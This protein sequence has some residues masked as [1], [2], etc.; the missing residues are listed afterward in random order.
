MCAT[1]SRD[2]VHSPTEQ[3]SRAAAYAASTPAWPAPMTMT[4]NFMKRP[5]MPRPIFRCRSARRCARAR[6]AGAGADD[7]VKLQAC[8]LKVAQDEL[9]GVCASRAC[10]AAL[11]VRQGQLHQQDVPDVGDRHAHRD[12]VGLRQ[13]AERI[14]AP[15]F[16]DALRR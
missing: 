12:S 6:L 9:F 10:A 14:A 2:S 15:Q 5:E 8:G 11:Q 3:P 4:S 16:I 1:V 7:L 13:L